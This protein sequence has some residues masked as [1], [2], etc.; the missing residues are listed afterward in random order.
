[1][2]TEFYIVALISIFVIG[3]IGGGMV[4]FLGRRMIINRQLRAAQRK[5]ART[6][7]EA[8]DEAKVILHEVKEE[9]EKVRRTAETEYRE[10]RSEL[11]RQENRLSSKT[12][13]MERRLEGV[14]QRER[15]LTNKEKGMESIRAELTEL[16]DR[17]LKQL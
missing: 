7:A 5:A 8:R 16:R 2:G 6:V 10:R 4:V 3:V 12:E 14:E 1:M 17:Q 15:N 9:A 13:T 11:Q